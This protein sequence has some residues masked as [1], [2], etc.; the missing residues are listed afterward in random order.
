M[1]YFQ[2]VSY[3]NSICYVLAQRFFALAFPIINA[4][5]FVLLITFV[6]YHSDV[7]YPLKF[8]IFTKFPEL[9]TH[10]HYLN[11]EHFCLP[12][13]KPDMNQQSLPFTLAPYP[14]LFT[15]A[16]LFP[17]Y[18]CQHISYQWNF[19]IC[20]LLSGFFHLGSIRL[21]HIYQYFILVQCLV[22][23]HWLDIPH[24]FIH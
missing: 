10:H 14:Q 24:L 13:K 6:S 21:Q 5:V 1:L 3:L 18:I 23:F 17:V 2:Q 22:I 7:F 12:Q 15:N 4:Q 11:L 9:F 16:H 20:S 8:N 19:T